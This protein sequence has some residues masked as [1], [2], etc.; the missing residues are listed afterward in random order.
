MFRDQKDSFLRLLSRGIE[1]P[2][3][4]ASKKNNERDSEHSDVLTASCFDKPDAA[5]DTERMVGEVG[6]G[7]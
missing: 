1:N 5:E 7:S 3:E 6:L 4:S 2:K